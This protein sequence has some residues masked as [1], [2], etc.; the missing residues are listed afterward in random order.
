MI[1]KSPPRPPKPAVKVYLGGREECNLKTKAGKEEY[2]ERTEQ[3]AQR[4]GFRCALCSLL[5]L[6][7]EETFDHECSRGGGKRD[8]R[9]FKEDGTWQNA[10][11]HW[12]CNYKKGSKRYHW[13]NNSKYVPV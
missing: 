1:R 12:I 6:H 4:Q 8:D 7:G 10:A 9:I 2:R 13:V 5:M 3:M 11:A